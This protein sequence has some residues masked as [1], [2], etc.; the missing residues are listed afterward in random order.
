MIR[1]DRY[2][3]VGLSSF[4]VAI[5]EPEKGSVLMTMN[6]NKPLP[7]NNYLEGFFSSINYFFKGPKETIDKLSERSSLSEGDFY[8]YVSRLRVLAKTEKGQVYIFG[9][10]SESEDN[11][12]VNLFEGVPDLHLNN[13]RLPLFLERMSPSRLRVRTLGSVAGAAGQGKVLHAQFEIDL[14]NTNFSN[15]KDKQLH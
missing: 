12:I 7:K 4:A 2:L 10:P 3:L 13:I 15:F 14:N 1:L 6:D 9:F 5:I 8:H 11:Q